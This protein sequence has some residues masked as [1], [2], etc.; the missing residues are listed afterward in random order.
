[1]KART[2]PRNRARSSSD[3]IWLY[4]DVQISD[5]TGPS[6]GRPQPEARVSG[7]NRFEIVSWLTPNSALSANRHR[8]EAEHVRMQ[9]AQPRESPRR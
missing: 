1:M 8:I 6:H 2:N 3:G 7:P 9:R 4:L 5:E